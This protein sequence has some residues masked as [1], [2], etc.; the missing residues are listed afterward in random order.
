GIND[1]SDCLVALMRGFVEMRIKPYYLHHADLAPGTGHFRT[2]IAHGQAL[3][4]ALRGKLS[5]LAQHTYVLDIPGG[6]GKV[7][8]GPKYIE[9]DG[10]VH[11][12]SGLAH[13]YPERG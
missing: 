5:G 9:A 10:H 6:D 1:D 13:D 11:D 12:P 8:T 7:P 2:S 3:M 4:R